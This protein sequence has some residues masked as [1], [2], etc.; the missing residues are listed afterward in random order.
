MASS[1]SL[2]FSFLMKKIEDIHSPV[3]VSCGGTSRLLNQNATLFLLRNHLVVLVFRMA[4]TSRSC[5]II[6]ILDAESYV[7]ENQKPT[8]A[9][10]HT[11][12]DQRA[13]DS[14]QLRNIIRIP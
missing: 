14:E 8:A 1:S 2:D 4:K 9:V 11:R 13:I 12:L 10:V 5:L 6:P 3:D 7:G